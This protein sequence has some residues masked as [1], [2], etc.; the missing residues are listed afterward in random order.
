MACQRRRLHRVSA[1]D[2]QRWRSAHDVHRT[3]I[4][5]AAGS[6]DRDIDRDANYPGPCAAFANSVA[7][8]LSEDKSGSVRN[9]NYA[10][11]LI[12]GE[13]IPFACE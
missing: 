4:R 3:L 6:V 2:L 7:V 8:V 12:V 11:L 9:S 13:G 5:T 1:S 10:L